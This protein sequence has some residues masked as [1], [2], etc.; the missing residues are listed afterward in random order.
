MKVAATAL[1]MLMSG[2]AMAQ[3]HHH[4]HSPYVF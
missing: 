4:G 3:D 1:L 2:P